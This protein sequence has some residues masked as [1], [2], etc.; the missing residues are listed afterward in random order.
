[1]SSLRKLMEIGI[2]ELRKLQVDYGDIRIGH[3]RRQ[4]VVARDT[5][6]ANLSDDESL[7][8][9]IR[10]FWKGYWGFY[11]DTTLTP[12]AIVDAA[13]QAV[14][15]ARAGS[16]MNGQPLSLVPVDRHETS[17]QVDC[18]IDPF[19]VPMRQ[20]IDLLLAI[21]RE[22][23]GVSGIGHAVASM[24]FARE[25][26]LFMSTVGTFTDQLI[27]R[28]LCEYTATAVSRKGFETRTFQ[29][30]PVNAGYEHIIER[31]LLGNARRIA[32]EAIE[33]LD[34]QFCPEDTL[35][36]VLLPNHTALVIHETIGHATELD[37]V[38][39]WEADFAGTSF[40][41][42]DKLGSF[43]YGSELFSVTG[44]RTLR[45]GRS[46]VAFDDDGVPTSKWHIIKNGIL[47]GYSTTRDTAGFIGAESS[48][49]CSFADSWNSMPILR[50]PNVSIEPGLPGSP[51]LDDIIAST[52]RGILVDGRGSFS[53][54]H[55]R[56]NFQFG[57][58]YCR[59]IEHGRLGPVLRRVT[60]QSHNP[61][62]WTSVDAIAPAE[63]WR[64][65]GVTNC[66]KGQPMQVAQLTHGSSPLRVRR[67]KVGRARI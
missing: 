3:Y 47:S 8:F 24:A 62:F 1:M 67:V 21:N 10:A 11:S 43:R 7:G 12:E 63:E 39:G 30:M 6:P 4:D 34:A 5:I 16:A 36:L 48:R 18:R 31:D 17:W 54:D 2:E 20:K 52:D 64:Q 58:D 56:I 19:E 59:L 51:R 28:A 14:A 42:L 50:M 38:L 29:T 33:K 26:K 57:G 37:R 41:T 27:V 60:Y 15:I 61:E 40:A 23:R 9:G 45:S 65:Y 49:G 46:T 25:H 32:Q 53:I 55:Q 13:R 44:D 22:L 35:D 66:G